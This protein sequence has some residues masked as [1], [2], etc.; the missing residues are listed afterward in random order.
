[1]GVVS[2]SLLFSQP[3]QG[4]HTSPAGC[5]LANVLPSGFLSVEADGKDVS[6][7]IRIPPE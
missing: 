3:H 1:M 5:S 6:S 7:R 4:R 2:G